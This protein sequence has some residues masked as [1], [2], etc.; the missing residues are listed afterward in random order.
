MTHLKL[1]QILEFSYFSVI[2]ICFVLLWGGMSV[3][4]EENKSFPNSDFVASAKKLSD[5]V[6]DKEIL[7]LMNVPIE[8][9]KQKLE[10]N[11]RFISLNESR[12]HFTAQH[13]KI[14]KTEFEFI[15]FNLL[16]GFTKKVTLIWYDEEGF[17]PEL[18]KYVQQGKEYVDDGRHKHV[19]EISNNEDMIYW[20][21]ALSSDI[22][23]PHHAS[24]IGFGHGFGGF[25]PIP[26]HGIL[27]ETDKEKIFIGIHLTG[28]YLGEWN[29]YNYNDAKLDHSKTFYWPDLAL[30]LDYYSKKNNLPKYPR[31]N[32]NTLS[33]EGLTSNPHPVWKQKNNNKIDEEIDN[34][35]NEIPEEDI[36]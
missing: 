3:W 15:K 2:T 4:G 23:R 36:H 6:S 32:F 7:N 16:R 11:V 25:A 13:E 30:F 10:T 29:I 22:I 20:K 26:P 19:Y 5:L 33:G 24:N 27:F 31:L 34:D 21:S 28:F 17:N 35:Q 8:I 18:L 1:E 14:L 12:E 9:T